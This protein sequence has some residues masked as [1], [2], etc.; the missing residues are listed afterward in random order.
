MR[1]A[2][3]PFQSPSTDS[4]GSP[5][6]LT[7]GSLTT[8]TPA[9]SGPV[10]ADL[11]TNGVVTP[12]PYLG[13][14]RRL[15][16]AVL[17]TTLSLAASVVLLSC[18]AGDKPSNP[19][20]GDGNGSPGANGGNGNGG[21]S[22]G[23]GSNRG[24]GPKTPV[25]GDTVEDDDF[26]LGGDLAD[27]PAPE[28]CG[29]GTLTTNEAC[30]DGNLKDGDGCSANCLQLEPGFSCAAPGKACQAIARCGDG[31]VASSEQCDD[32]N[33]V[34]GDGCSERC[35]IELGKKCEGSPSV[36]TD[37]ECGDGKI[38]GAEACDDGNKQPFDGC[39][40][41]CLR[42]P[43]C[44]GLSC[45][46]DCGDGLVINEECDDGNNIDGDGC[47]STCKTEEGFACIQQAVCDKLD[48][49]SDEC[50]LRVPAIFRD[51]SGSHPDFLDATGDRITAGEVLTGLV[52]AELDADGKPA[53]SG[54]NQ[55]AA[56]ISSAESFSEWYRD[57]KSEFTLVGELVLFDNGDGG[58]VNRFGSEGEQF[59]SIDKTQEQGAGA[60]LQQCE[61][62]CAEMARNA[63][64]S[65]C[66]NLCRP[67]TDAVRQTDQQLQQATQQLAD[68]E[69]QLD[70]QIQQAI[71]QG[72]D[73]DAG[74]PIGVTQAQER[75]D[76]AEATI[77][78]LTQQVADLT[79]I[80]EECTT[81]CED[82]VA[83]DTKLCT[84]QCGPCSYDPDQYCIGG[85][86]VYWDGNPL[87]FPVD[88]ATGA[89]VDRGRAK[90]PEQYGYDGWPWEDEW[91][92][93]APAHNFY[94]TSEV[95]YWFRF[96]EN[97]NATLAFTGDDDVWV[98]INGKLAVDLGG[99]HVPEDGT[100]TINQASAARFDLE[101]GN[102]YTIKVFHA[103]RQ[104]EGS[105]FK[106]TLSGFEATPSECKADCGDGVLSFGEE[107]DDGVNDGGYGECA[108][109]CVLGPYCGDGIVQPGEDCDNGPGGGPGCP[110]CRIL[111]IQ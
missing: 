5:S 14:R 101:P 23:S 38:E 22:S 12:L 111:I 33:R 87:F 27:L 105:S 92:P 72:I 13:S 52:N 86:L 79:A 1:L 73:L 56:H 36:C 89:T 30:D 41:V 63:H 32:G 25:P 3:P 43:N 98:F 17:S 74:A 15:R 48:P 47:S 110:N 88:S 19:G 78:T 45:T 71:N 50:I 84:T 54:T 10:S 44:E 53:L 31:L 67:R 95:Q 49:D 65:G 77:E 26:I 16:T 85:E 100:V 20:S 81:E 103:E 62:R 75:V 96:E 11:A 99:V 24:D 39:S 58:Y 68:A 91:F 28:G 104:M 9:L 57:G 76:A 109:G 46:S 4:A 64:G 7:T 2:Q 66:D 97:T 70:D 18:A 42:E 69:R 90:I 34:A 51:F 106:L 61:A 107:C 82:E 59:T 83:E 29:D 108:E 94:F 93:D 60:N 80:A 6:N 8:E 35:R 102:V 21:G 37:A 55:R 40:A